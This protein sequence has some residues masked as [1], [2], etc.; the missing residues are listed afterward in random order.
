MCIPGEWTSRDGEARI[1]GMVSHPGK[2]R[3][4]TPER[5]RPD[6]V[7]FPLSRLHSVRD[8]HNQR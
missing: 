2:N 4:L 5:T 7:N 3:A 8:D 6:A 1:T